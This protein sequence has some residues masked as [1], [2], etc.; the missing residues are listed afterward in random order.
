MSSTQR[1]A[2]IWGIVFLLA[3]VAGA[4]PGLLGPDDATLRVDALHGR[5]LGLFPVNVLHDLVHLVF[6]IWG[7]FAS[8]S[9]PQ[10]KLY[11]RVTAIA[12]AVLVV[13]GFLPGLQT[14]FGLVPIHSHDIWLHLVL[15]LPAAYFGFR[16]GAPAVAT[17]TPRA[18][19]R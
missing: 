17:T 6:G 19:S 4:V 14:L 18:A 11:A 10:A 9:L 16:S 1:F 7:L 3:A 5:L 2:L 12:Y 15:A 8:R 13:A